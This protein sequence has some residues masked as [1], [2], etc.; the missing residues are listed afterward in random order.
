MNLINPSYDILTICCGDKE[1]ELIETAGRTCYK[2]ER[3]ITTASSTEFV[4]NAIKRGHESIL[5]HSLMTVRFICD[6]G[7]S[8]EIVRHRLASF[9]QE[10]TRYCNYSK[11]N[12]GNEL[13]FIIPSFFTTDQAAYKHWLDAMQTA[14]DTYLWLIKDGYKP[15]EARSVLPNSI[16]TEI[17]MS[18]N[19]R[20][21]RHFFQIRAARYAGK[22]HPQMEELA[23]P[24]LA[25]CKRLVPIIFDDIVVPAD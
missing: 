14:E 12:F 1:L 24:L 20:E 4:R 23:R 25:E 22:A 7:V 3:F 6:R 16:K 17:V 2:S 11:D 19:F 18:A 8:H 21:W 5:E 10:S 13:T 9:S 15:E